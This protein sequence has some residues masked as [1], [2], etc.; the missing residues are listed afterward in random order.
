MAVWSLSVV[1]KTDDPCPRAEITLTGLTAGDSTVT[2]W[3]TTD[4]I[5]EAVRGAR[6]VTVNGSAFWTDYEAPTN[7]VLSYSLE[8]TGGAGVADTGSPAGVSVASSS[9]WIQDPLVP[10]SAMALGVTK[11]DPSVPTLTSAAV[12]E[13]EYRSGVQ[14]I[15]IMGSAAP[16]AIT[17]QRLAAAGVD[18]SMFTDAAEAATSL[19]NLLMQASVLLVR[20]GT[21]LGDVLPG[22]VYLAVGAP[23]EIPVT[24]PLGG[25]LTRW[26]LT[27]DT[28][29]APSMS[30]LVPVWTYGEVEAIWETYQQD[31]NAKGAGTYLDDLKN[32]AGA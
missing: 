6:K 26:E 14:V 4:G 9:W 28:V 24:V 23:K 10:E 15:P 11:G 7:R 2:V 12:R 27:G 25:S 16:I 1:A 30:I 3:R 17:G 32:P 29:A 31:L 22:S 5:R 19:R 13:L 20:P 18:F 21:Q 8:V